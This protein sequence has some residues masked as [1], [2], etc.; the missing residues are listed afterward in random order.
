MSTRIETNNDE[1]HIVHARD[2]HQ[3]G[4][5]DVSTIRI[6]GVVD[7][8]LG[9]LVLRLPGVVDRYF[10]LGPNEARE[11]RDALVLRVRDAT[12]DEGGKARDQA[13]NAA[14]SPARFEEV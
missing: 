6:G 12:E 10:A 2:L 14:I 1:F 5:T 7:G 9:C 4:S 3:V 11:L 13:I 8:P